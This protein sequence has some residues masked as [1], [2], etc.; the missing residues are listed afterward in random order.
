ML[1]NDHDP[2]ENLV[3]ASLGLARAPALGSV[4]VV[5]LSASEVLVR[6]T[7][8]ATDGVDSFAY[9]VCDTL[10]ACATA[11]V[12]VT[13]GTSR[14][15]IV[16]TDGDDILRGTPGGDVICGLGGHDVICGLGGHDVISGLGGNDILIG[17]PGNDALYGGHPIPVG[18]GDGANVL[19]GGAGHD[20]LVGGGGNDTI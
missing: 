12:T 18:V 7:G 17:G 9:E 4:R 11:E 5:A 3:A 20:T 1:T 13:V 6:Y 19:F 2:D 15:T 8:G 14:C 16:G 10:G